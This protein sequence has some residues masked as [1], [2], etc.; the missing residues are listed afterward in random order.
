MTQHG[1]VSP[2]KQTSQTITADLKR[3]ARLLAVDGRV[4]HGT[5]GLIR[6]ALDMKDPYLE[7]LVTRVE[8][9]EMRID[10]LVLDG[11]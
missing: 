7:Q 6:L 11:D 9:G 3:R 4:D 2:H 1:S 5:R 10:H 8:A